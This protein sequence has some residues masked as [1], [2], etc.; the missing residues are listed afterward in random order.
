MVKREKH[1][2]SLKNLKMFTSE[3]QPSGKAK[4]EGKRKAQTMRELA[5]LFGAG[6]PSEKIVEAYLK[7]Y[8]ELSK[9]EV[10]ND[11]IVIAGQYHKAQ[12]E[13]DTNAARYITDLKGE[14]KSNV[15]VTAPIQIV[16]SQ[17]CKNL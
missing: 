2:N 3:Y 1:E 17:K 8:P 15:E 12:T 10:S 5:N 11:L 9:E 14:T 7:V 4:S 6:V 13:K 16:F